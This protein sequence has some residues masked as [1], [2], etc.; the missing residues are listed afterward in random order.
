ME[1]KS[2]KNGYTLCPLKNKIKL[3][4]KNNKNAYM[5]CPF[6]NKKNEKKYN[7]NAF[8]LSF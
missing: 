3:K 8:V 2:N 6:K 5:F 4:K 1:K 7:K